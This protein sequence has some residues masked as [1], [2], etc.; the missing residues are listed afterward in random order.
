MEVELSRF[1]KENNILELKVAEEH[2]KLK[3]KEDEMIVE[4]TKVGL[5]LFSTHW[6]S[7]THKQ[8]VSL[9]FAHP[10]TH[11]SLGR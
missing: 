4:R 2:K 5:Q 7:R 9:Y 3:A 8:L 1:Q 6:S 10:H 11:T